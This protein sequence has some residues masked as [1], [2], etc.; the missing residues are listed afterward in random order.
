[1]SL[2]GCVNDSNGFYL[3]P[4]DTLSY[5]N[6]LPDKIKLLYRG[7][8]IGKATKSDDEASYFFYS[9]AYCLVKNTRVVLDNEG[10]IQSKFVFHVD[11]ILKC[12]EKNECS[13]DTLFYEVKTGQNKKIE[14]KLIKELRTIV[15]EMDSFSKSIE[16]LNK[17]ALKEDG[18]EN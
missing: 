12:K 9:D 1:L 17:P 3:L 11:T 4:M 15:Q 5:N 2:E 8:E 16:H 13:S 18:I 7:L 6:Q 14:E 10:F